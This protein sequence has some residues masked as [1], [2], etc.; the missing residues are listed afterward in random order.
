MEKAD[1]DSP[2]RCKHQSAT[3]QCDF[4]AQ[5]GYDYCEKHCKM[6]VGGYKL[7]GLFARVTEIARSPEAKGIATEKAILKHQLEVTMNSCETEADMLVN[8][9]KM[10][11]LAMQIS[12]LALIDHKLNVANGRMLD[13]ETLGILIDDISNIIAE[14]VTDKET[15][16]LIAEGIGHAIE[17]ATANAAQKASDK[18]ITE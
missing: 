5:R 6:N 11:N 18:I 7:K 9:H 1:A 12:K 8:E 16:R 4:E 17:R 10:T 14:H 13:A 3:K 15:Q 2:T